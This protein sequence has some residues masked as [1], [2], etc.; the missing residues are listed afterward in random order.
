MATN[1]YDEYGLPGSGNLGRFQYTG[2]AWIPELG[3]YHYKARA[4]SPSLGRFMQPDPSGYGDGLNLYAYVHNDPVN[5]IDPTG[6]EGAPPTVNCKPDGTDC[7]STEIVVTAHRPNLFSIIISTIFSLPKFVAI[8]LPKLAMPQTTKAPTICGGGDFTFVG[9]EL[10]LAEGGGFT[11]AIV[12][13]D[14]VD[15]TSAGSLNEAWVGGEG[16]DVGAGKITGT[17]TLSSGK[18]WF[19]FGGASISAGPFAG[20]QAGVVTNPLDGW[21]GLYIEGHFGAWTRGTGAYLRTSC[22]NGH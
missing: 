7:E 12:E 6:L 20:L 17:N 4:Y 13:N 9:R 5:E 21:G 15:G 3:L 1:T 11:G 10:D 16:G 19:G 14:T 8:S 22:G 18:G 2:Q